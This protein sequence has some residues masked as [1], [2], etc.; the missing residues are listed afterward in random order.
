MPRS[1]AI[2][3]AGICGTKHNNDAYDQGHQKLLHRDACA[4][5]DYATCQNNRRTR[6]GRI[7][8]W[9]GKLQTWFGFQI[10]ISKWDK[11]LGKRLEYRKTWKF[12]YII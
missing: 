4:S 10:S 2:T 8:S 6:L 7:P 12:I 9:A 5:K 11:N 1:H 3:M